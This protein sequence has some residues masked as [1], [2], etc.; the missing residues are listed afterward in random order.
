MESHE[1]ELEVIELLIQHENAVGDLYS[2]YA[3]KFMDMEEF[4]FSI[5][6]DERKHASWIQGTLDKVKEGK[7]T[8]DP[9]VFKIEAVKESL[10]YVKKLIKEAEQ[11]DL[12]PI[13]ALQN[14]FDIERTMIEDKFFEVFGD[15]PS[16]IKAV[17]NSLIEGTKFHVK[18]VEQELIRRKKLEAQ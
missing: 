17:L 14:A 9:A 12:K 2:V 1:D 5:V 16:D 3:R 15:I 7:V 6:Q 11:N 8:F 18:V 10:D 4:W 13:D